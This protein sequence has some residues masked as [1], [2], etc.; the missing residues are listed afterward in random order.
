MRSHRAE[1]VLPRRARACHTG[2]T[3][4]QACTSAATKRLI[5]GC[6]PR[7][8]PSHVG[9]HRDPTQAALLAVRGRGPLRRISLGWSIIAHRMRKLTLY[10]AVLAALSVCRAD[11]AQVTLLSSNGVRE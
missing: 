6:L 9:S 2:N 3:R 10:T 11:A 7:F 5:W 1:T 8:P 4:R